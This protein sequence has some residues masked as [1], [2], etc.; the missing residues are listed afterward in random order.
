MVHGSILFKRINVILFQRLSFLSSSLFVCCISTSTFFFHAQTFITIIVQI[1]FTSIGCDVISLTF[2]LSRTSTGSLYQV[3]RTFLNWIERV[4]TSTFNLF[5]ASNSYSIFNL[6]I[7]S[8]SLPTKI[9]SSKKIK[10]RLVTKKSSLSPHTHTLELGIIILSIF[11][12]F[13][14]VHIINVHS[15]IKPSLYAL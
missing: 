14:H 10:Q 4:T 12:N 6:C 13:L 11:I 5:T 2:E 15:S 3:T 9:T 1:S 8:S 7:C